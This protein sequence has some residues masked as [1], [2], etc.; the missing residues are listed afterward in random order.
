MTEGGAETRVC[1]QEAPHVHQC[2]PRHRD[3]RRR[4]LA[5]RRPA[6]GGGARPAG[7]LGRG[8]RPAQPDLGPPA[9]LRRGDAAQR[10]RRGLFRSRG[11]RQGTGPGA[12]GG[13]AQAG[14]RPALVG[15]QPGPHARPQRRPALHLG[16]GRAVSLAGDGFGGRHPH[17]RNGRTRAA[18]PLRLRRRFRAD[19]APDP[20]RPGPAAGRL[21]GAHGAQ[22][23]AGDLARRH[24]AA[25]L[26]PSPAAPRPWP[27]RPAGRP[28]G[29]WRRSRHRSGCG[30]GAGW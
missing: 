28:S 7:L 30:R 10:P 26:Q 11:P 14:P 2:R 5:P 29:R 6:R 17:D 22:G 19:R 8:G 18:R 21:P 24:R 27:S 15:P 20:A 1:Y 4:G 13:T 3:L 23:L 12:G 9:R 16:R 25:G